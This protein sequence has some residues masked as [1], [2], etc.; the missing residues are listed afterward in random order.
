MRDVPKEISELVRSEKVV[1]F[2]KGTPQMPKCG[3][4]ATVCRIL[5]ARGVGYRTVDVLTDPEI[6]EGVK[7][8][9]SWPTIPQLYIDGEFVGGCDIA[10]E[11]DANGELDG[12]LRK[13][14]GAS[15]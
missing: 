3:F 1:L 6:R 10:K 2:M 15:S 14:A 4:S 11:L 7:A 12:L 13:A 9:A 8:Y 5:D